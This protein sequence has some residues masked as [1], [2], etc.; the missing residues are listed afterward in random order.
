M[1]RNTCRNQY[2][3]YVKYNIKKYVAVSLSLKHF[4]EKEQYF[5][6]LQRFKIA[7]GSHCCVV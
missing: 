2:R 1:F 3:K 4:V 7:P 6:N 5:K